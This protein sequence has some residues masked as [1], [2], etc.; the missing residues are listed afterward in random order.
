MSDPN[1]A[2]KKTVFHQLFQIF[3]FSFS[4][5]DRDHALMENSYPSRIITPVLKPPKTT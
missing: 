2:I 1:V 5:T 3:D 4:A